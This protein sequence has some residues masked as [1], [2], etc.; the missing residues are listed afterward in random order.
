MGTTTAK[1][2]GIDAIIRWFASRQFD[3]VSRRQLL[4]AAVTPDQIAGRVARG[5]LVRL[6]RG[7]YT[8]AAAALRFEGRLFAALLAAPADAVVSHRSA[9]T[10]R[11]LLPERRGPVDLTTGGCHHARTGIRLHRAVGHAEA[12][13]VV[14]GIPCSTVPRTLVDVAGSEGAAAAERAWRTLAGRGAIQVGRVEDELRRSRHRPGVPVVRRLLDGHRAVV[15]G[16]SRSGLESLAIAMC[17]RFGLPM[18]RLNHLVDTGGGIFEIDLVWDDARVA[19]EIDDWSTHG[20]PESF[21]SGRQ[22]DLE[23][24][25]AGW[26]TARLIEQDLTIGARRTAERLRR[27]LDRAPLPAA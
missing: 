12:A 21:R 5:V 27:L 13:T 24:G 8:I 7:V 22:R 20:S 18:P 1:Q 23:L 14:S 25:A 3:V 10:L 4:A 19:V 11:G 15:S 2:Q 17:E 26:R 16:R 9:A 6:H